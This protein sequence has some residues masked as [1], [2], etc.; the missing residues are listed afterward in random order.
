MALDEKIKLDL[1]VEMVQVL[2]ERVQYLSHFIRMDK[3]HDQGIKDKIK[4][5]KDK[6]E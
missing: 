3:T 6:I 1:L 4:K 5:I 2:S